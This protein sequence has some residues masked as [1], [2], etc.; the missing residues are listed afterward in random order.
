MILDVTGDANEVVSAKIQMENVIS[1]DRYV[2]L[3]YFHLPDLPLLDEEKDAFDVASSGV[4]QTVPAVSSIEELVNVLDSF[5]YNGARVF[6]AWYSNNELELCTGPKAVALSASFAALIKMPTALTANTCYSASLFERQ[7]SQYSHYAVRVGNARGEWD[8][9]DFNEFIA[10][11]RRAGDNKIEKH[12]FRRSS[13]TVDLAVFT[14]KKDGTI[15]PY[16]S[17]DIW[18]LGLEIA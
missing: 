6:Y 14:V 7:I 17:P 9:T 5:E 15:V 4:L 2:R 3:N 10:R 18:A 8:G 12:Y 13:G 1:T 11:V 16:I